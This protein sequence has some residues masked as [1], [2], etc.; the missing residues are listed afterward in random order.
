[1]RYKE[2]H[3]RVNPIK[4]QIDELRQTNEKQH[5]IIQVLQRGLNSTTSE[6]TNLKTELAKVQKTLTNLLDN[7]KKI[8]K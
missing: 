3:Y 1:M 2:Y 7:Y 4:K 8:L 6:C 5:F